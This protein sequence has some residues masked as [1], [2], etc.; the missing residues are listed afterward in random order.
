MANCGPKFNLKFNFR[1]TNLVI[2][3]KNELQNRINEI[4]IVEWME[5][6]IHSKPFLIEPESVLEKNGGKLEK[7]AGE[8]LSVFLWG[9]GRQDQQLVSSVKFVGNDNSCK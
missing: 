4:G 1:G 8:R 3:I 5:L 9:C 7:T 6:M 2:F